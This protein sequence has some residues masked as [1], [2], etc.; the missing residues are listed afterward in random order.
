MLD[1]PYAAYGS[2]LD[3]ARMRARCLGAELI[4]PAIL[5]GWKLRLRRFASIVEAPGEAVPVGLWR[6]NAAHLAALDRAEGVALGA[7][8]RIRVAL[9]GG[10]E[11]WVYVEALNRPG[12]PGAAYVAHLRQGYGA[13]GLPGSVLAAA[14]SESGFRG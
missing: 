10:G 6:I 2:N 14:I 11:A 4:G 3:P 12:L 13:F 1:I 9:T 7:Y 8:R 5:P